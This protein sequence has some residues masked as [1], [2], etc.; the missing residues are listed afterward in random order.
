MEGTIISK[1][2]KSDMRVY[3]GK[4]LLVIGPNGEQLGVMKLEPACQAA[5]DAGLDLVM[6]A[7]NSE[8]PVCRIMNFGK[9][10]YEQ[11]KKLKDQKKNQQA[12]K[13]KEIKFRLNIA[14]HDYAHKIEQGIEFLSDGCKLKV[15]ITF[16]GREMARTEIGF[17]LASRITEDLSE[18]GSI[19]SPAKLFGKNLNMSF[20]PKGSH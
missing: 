12:Q 19:E 4:D 17:D 3:A 8:P 2:L 7:E 1:L 5:K 10:L 13:V 15:T 9:L 6:V 18:N 16:K 14:E 20:N 11:K